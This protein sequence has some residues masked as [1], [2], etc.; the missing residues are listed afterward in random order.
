MIIF[1]NSSRDMYLINS[2]L[3]SQKEIRIKSL[4]VFDDPRII[5]YKWRSNHGMTVT[6]KG[7]QY[8][9]ETKTLQRIITLIVTE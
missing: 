6:G 4:I 9:R 5:Y 1:K 7:K 3:E 2:P 8:S